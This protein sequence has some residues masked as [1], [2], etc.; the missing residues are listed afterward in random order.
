[1]SD[2]CYFEIT[3]FKKDEAIFEALGF[4]SQDTAD[5][6]DMV[7]EEYTDTDDDGELPDNICWLGKSGSGRDFN[8]NR[9]VC[10]GSGWLTIEIGECGSPVVSWDYERNEPVADSLQHIKNFVTMA[11]QVN[12]MFEN[13]N[14]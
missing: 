3:C 8:A 2:R 10:N 1:M 5:V 7:C 14:E 12:L 11:K 6:I 13:V 4:V 9:Y